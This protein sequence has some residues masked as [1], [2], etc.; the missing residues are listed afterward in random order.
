M[1]IC[2]SSFQSF[3]E[4]E[5]YAQNAGWR[6]K[7]TTQLHFVKLHWGR[8]WIGDAPQIASSFLPFSLIKSAL[9]SHLMLTSASQPPTHRHT[10]SRANVQE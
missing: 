6:V 4:T 10:N 2:W 7:T 1:L 8:I 5:V 9:Q 3:V